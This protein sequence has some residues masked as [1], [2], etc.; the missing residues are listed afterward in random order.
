MLSCMFFIDKGLAL[1][2]PKMGQKKSQHSAQLY[3]HKVYLHR[4][5]NTLFIA[6]KFFVR[7]ENIEDYCMRQAV[8]QL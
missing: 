8:L 2:G 4:I 3:S 5:T 1:L 6:F 7:K